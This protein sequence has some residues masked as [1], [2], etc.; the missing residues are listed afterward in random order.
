VVFPKS[1]K[2]EDPEIFDY[3]DGDGVEKEG[4]LFEYEDFPNISLHFQD[5]EDEYQLIKT[6]QIGTFSGKKSKIQN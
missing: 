4:E 5:V 6:I 1:F 3:T 2:K